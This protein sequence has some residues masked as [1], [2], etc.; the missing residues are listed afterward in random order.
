MAPRGID[1]R[2]GGEVDGDVMGPGMVGAC[3]LTLGV[4]GVR[5]QGL[6]ARE[7]RSV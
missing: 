2:G 7:V 1:C 6:G 4:H 3:L 5:N